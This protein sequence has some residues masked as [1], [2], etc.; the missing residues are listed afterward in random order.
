MPTQVGVSLADQ[1]EVVLWLNSMK[2]G[3]S[4]S[5]CGFGGMQN[6]ASTR[7]R[8]DV[9][10]FGP[11]DGE[12]RRWSTR[13]RAGPATRAAATHVIVPMWLFESLVIAAP[14]SL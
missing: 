4:L 7:R 6:G 1:L 13:Q 5:V 11:S 14:P 9:R 3:S 2:H 12:A 10:S 8:R